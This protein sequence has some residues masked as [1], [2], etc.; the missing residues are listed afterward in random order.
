MGF[1]NLIVYV[2][3]YMTFHK[4]HFLKSFKFPKHFFRFTTKMINN[5]ML[6]IV[7]VMEYVGGRE[8]RGIVRLIFHRYLFT[9]EAIAPVV[10]E[11]A[12]WEHFDT[13]TTSQMQP[14]GPLTC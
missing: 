5:M 11:L 4:F 14:T 8:D 12:W 9:G 3:T 6:L 1:P 7:S 13:A 2:S 10:H